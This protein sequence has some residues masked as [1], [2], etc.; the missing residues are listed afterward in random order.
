MGG[1]I[2]H[3]TQGLGGLEGGAQDNNKVTYY[4]LHVTN[5]WA[6]GHVTPAK[7]GYYASIHSPT[8]TIFILV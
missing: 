1:A 4:I 3:V 6:V 8:K 5:G 7:A 2:G